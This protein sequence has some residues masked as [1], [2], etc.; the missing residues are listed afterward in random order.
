MT[1]D[2]SNVRVAVTGA[3]LKGATS[4]VAPTGTSG[5]PTGFEDLGYIGEEGVEITLPEVGDSEVIR[6]WQ[7]NAIVRIIRTPSEDNPTWVFAMMETKKEVIET[8]FGV[9]ITETATEGSFEWSSN[10]VRPHNS[11][12]VDSIDGAEL[13]RDYIPKGIVTG[14]ESHTLT[15]TGATTYQVTV[16]G[17]LDS[18]KGYNFKRWSTALKSA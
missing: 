2:A 5:A 9:A 6:A 1:L 15:S 11:Y 8:Y 4:A 16:E 17:E 10:S 7:E 3:V 14:V 13:T 12:I 18:D